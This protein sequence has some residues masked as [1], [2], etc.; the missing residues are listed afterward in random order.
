MEK[1]NLKTLAKELDFQSEYEYFEY[2]IDSYIN[3]NFEQCKRLFSEM[4]KEDQKT[5]VTMA[6]VYSKEIGDFYFSLL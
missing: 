6:A 1:K 5:L 2:C 4:E 3:G